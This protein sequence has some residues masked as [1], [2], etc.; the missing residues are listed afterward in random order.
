MYG[1]MLAM[2][3]RGHRVL[4]AAPANSAIARKAAAAG[5][6][7]LTFEDTRAAFPP[8]L[9]RLA[10][11]FR[12]QRA[13]IVNTHSSRDG[14]L[15]GIAARLV[16]TPLLLR[17]RHIEVDYPNRLL[18][19]IAFR[20][21]PHH[22]LTTSRRISQRLL[23][24]LGLDPER[25]TCIPTGVDLARF[26][27]GSPGSLHAELKLDPR[28]PL[29]GMISVL[30][31]WKGHEFFIGA[32]QRIAQ[33]HPETHFVIAG[34]GPCRDLIRSRIADAGLE[35]RFHCLGHRDDV[36]AI[37]ASLTV[38]A[39]PS[40]AHE[41]IPQIILQAQ[42]MGK[43][44]VASAVGGI[45]E[46][47]EDGVT[48]LLAPPSDAAALADRIGRLLRDS[49]LRARLGAN[50]RE[51]IEREHSIDAMC[52]RLEEIYDRYLGLD[53]SGGDR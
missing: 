37:L 23:Q 17:S 53:P 8:N 31:S 22:V 36:P 16:Q 3:T 12:H 52:R 1:E 40:T 10:R 21:L 43:A 15:A 49:G 38:L 5:F 32:A 47:V 46:V 48:G 11:W 27:P 42:A 26:D 14:W 33:T 19:R 28:V 24:E 51:R 34:D 6:A 7:T 44:V 4:L 20:T 29:T 25:V 18:S 9:I 13:E 39:L 2:R 41:G 35:D 45:P 50:S 30:R